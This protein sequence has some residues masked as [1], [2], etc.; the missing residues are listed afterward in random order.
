MS[1][2]KSLVS[3]QNEEIPGLPVSAR[4]ATPLFISWAAAATHSD[5]FPL[6]D[7]NTTTSR[8]GTAFP[9]GQTVK[10]QTTPH[11]NDTHTHTRTQQ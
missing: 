5:V 9:D 3:I 8:P 10:N 6:C 4:V 7:T 1:E 11:K 2:V